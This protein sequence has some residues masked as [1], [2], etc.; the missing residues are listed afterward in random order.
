MFGYLIG[1]EWL[2]SLL[3]A[4]DSVGYKLGNVPASASGSGPDVAAAADCTTAVGPVATFCGRLRS[5]LVVILV[6][7]SAVCVAEAVSDASASGAKQKARWLA[8]RPTR[9]ASEYLMQAL[10]W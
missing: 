9:C 6:P 4:A 8:T 3:L 7:A 5:S 10:L 2:Y 1:R